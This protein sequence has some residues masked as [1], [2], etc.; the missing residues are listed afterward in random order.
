MENG[1]IDVTYR[2][3]ARKSIRNFAMFIEEKG[4]QAT[5][6]KFVKSLMVFGNSLNVFPEKYTFCRKASLANRKFRCA[7]FKKNYIFIYK[8]IENE[9][10]IYNVIHT[11][12]YFY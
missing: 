3:R 12:R 1:K 2:E 9:L 7:I 4:Y 10:I 6:D 8:I 11:S 5:A